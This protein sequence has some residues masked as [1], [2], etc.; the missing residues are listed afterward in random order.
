MLFQLV[1]T[2]HFLKCHRY[3]IST[4]TKVVGKILF[5]MFTSPTLFTVKIVFHHFMLSNRSFFMLSSLCCHKLHCFLQPQ[6]WYP[7]IGFLVINPAHCKSYVLLQFHKIALSVSNWSFVSL[8]SFLQPFCSL[9]CR[10]CSCNLRP[11]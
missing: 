11:L 5:L 10:T 7:I 8:D 1:S 9:I 2:F 4:M 6:V 3:G